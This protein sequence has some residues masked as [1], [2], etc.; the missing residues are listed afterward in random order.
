M[1]TPPS[2]Q[3]EMTTSSKPMEVMGWPE[4][5]RDASMMPAMEAISPVMVKM[6]I[7]VRTTLTPARRA[8]SSL[9]PMARVLRPK[10]VLL[11]SRP[12]STK[13]SAVSQTGVGIPNRAEL[14]SS[15]KPSSTMPTALPSEMM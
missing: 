13:Q 12:K 4:V 1:E 10:V 3:A 9:P 11:S 7:L 15:K 2:T 5:M 14:P 6:M 8:A